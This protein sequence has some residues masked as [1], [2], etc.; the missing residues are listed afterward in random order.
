MPGSA[1]PLA[2]L[3]LL[4]WAADSARVARS[5]IREA[6]ASGAV[7]ASK[8]FAHDD[9]SDVSHASFAHG[10]VSNASGVQL[11]PDAGAGSVRFTSVQSLDAGADAAGLEIVHRNESLQSFGTAFQ[12][13]GRSAGLE[14]LQLSGKSAGLVDAVLDELANVKRL[15]GSS[16]YSGDGESRLG[17][18]A[19]CKCHWYQRCYPKNVAVDTGGSINVGGCGL[20]VSLLVFLSTLLFLTLIISI[21]ALRAWYMMDMPPTPALNQPVKAKRQ[22]R[23]SS[24]YAVP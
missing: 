4:L 21:I 22:M 6:N 9:V 10:V 23:T 2:C 5:V 3:C 8:E 20:G 14:A 18:S 16:C 12:L 15:D 7:A 24:Q 19:S 17:C 13:A 11:L 1:L